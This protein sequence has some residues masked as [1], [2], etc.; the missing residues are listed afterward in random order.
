MADSKEETS[1]FVY[2][3]SKRGFSFTQIGVCGTGKKPPHGLCPQLGIS[4][5]PFGQTTKVARDELEV[6]D[7]VKMGMR[8]DIR[9]IG[10]PGSRAAHR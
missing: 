2:D 8:I 1:A 7:I 6:G 5:T 9:D 3:K 4:M 10:D